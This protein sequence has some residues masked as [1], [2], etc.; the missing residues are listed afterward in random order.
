MNKTR[1]VGDSWEGPKINC[2]LDIF[3]TAATNEVNF[4]AQVAVT[5]QRD[6]Y[7]SQNKSLMLRV[8]DN[9]WNFVYQNG[10]SLYSNQST[11]DP[12]TSFLDFYA[13]LII[14]LDMDSYVELG[15]SDYFSKA[16]GIANFGAASSFSSGWTLNSNAYN[17]RK[18]VEDLNNDI[19]RPFR[20]GEF[21][22]Y[23]GIDV[24]SLNKELG[25]KYIVK[26]VDAIDKSKSKIDLTG[27]LMKTFFN[28]KYEEIIDRLKDY[29]DRYDVFLILKKLDPAHGSK[30][31][32]AMNQ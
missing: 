27:V 17:R 28:S 25:E 23:Y 20:E 15:G 31:D 6:I 10:Q 16:S 3:F 1:F 7:N 24:F 2:S 14:G 18:L 32:D 30:Y 4:T 11:F 19:Y 22:Y 8:N 9:S 29:P 12:L 5:S 13:N 26:L 21:D